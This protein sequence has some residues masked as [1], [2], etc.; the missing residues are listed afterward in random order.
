[1]S[2]VIVY[3]ANWCGHCQRLQPT[4]NEQLLH[5]ELAKRGLAM[6]IVEHTENKNMYGRPIDVNS[7]PCI[8]YK[9]AVHQGERDVSG[10]LAFIDSH[11]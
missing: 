8:K 10:I 2:V 1:M 5:D 3:K 6:V 7:F 9:G 11:S 4:L